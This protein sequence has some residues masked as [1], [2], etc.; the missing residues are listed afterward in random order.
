[1]PGKFEKIFG[2]LGVV[3]ENLFDADIHYLAAHF[4]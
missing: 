4:S 3:K 2:K 1:M